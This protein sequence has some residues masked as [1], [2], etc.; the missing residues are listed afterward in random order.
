MAR[1]AV[2]NEDKCKPKKCGLICMR[3]CPMVKS[4]VEAIRLED[5]KPVIGESLC[6]GCGICVRKCPFKALS[7]FNVPDEL[8][9]DCSHR[10]GVN[11]FKLYRLPT[12]M[13]GE[14]LG[15]LGKN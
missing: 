15:L 4:R 12:P 3:F 8:E 9:S 10:Y 5:Q 13:P 7:I 6:V 2:L 11:A 1:I 14:V